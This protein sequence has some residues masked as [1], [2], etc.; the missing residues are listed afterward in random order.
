VAGWKLNI[1]EGRR[2]L[3]FFGRAKFYEGKEGGGRPI[4]QIWFLLLKNMM[5]FFGEKG[6]KDICTTQ[7]LLKVA[8][9]FLPSQNCFLGREMSR[10]GGMKLVTSFLEVQN[11][12][13][14]YGWKCNQKSDE[15]EKSI[16]KKYFNNYLWVRWCK[17]LA[18]IVFGWSE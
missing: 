13:K 7:K 5:T 18:K 17:F 2:P 4:L 15:M 14:N 3:P 6:T 9:F 12:P 10:K 1:V 8:P 16:Q 11:Q